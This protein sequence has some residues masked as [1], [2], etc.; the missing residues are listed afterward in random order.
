MD[1]THQTEIPASF[2]ALYLNPGQARPKVPHALALQRYELCEDM[3]QALT[4]TAHALHFRTS[5]SHAEVLRCLQEGLGGEDAALQDGEAR[6]VICRLAEL[7]N[8]AAPAPDGV[9]PEGE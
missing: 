3:A 8:W 5:A 4:D 7:L 1:D 6:W 9:S 2:V